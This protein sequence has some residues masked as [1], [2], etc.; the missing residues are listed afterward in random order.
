MPA[1]TRPP[2]RSAAAAREAV[3]VVPR[4]RVLPGGGWHGVR[5]T[6]L[7]QALE[8]IAACGEFRPRGEVEEEPSWQQVIPHMVVRTDHGL[9]V[10]RRLTASSEARLHHQL[11]LGV[12]GHI[13][14]ADAA[15]GGDPLTAGAV[16]EW[17]EEVLC[18]VALAATL[19]GLLKDD[20]APV[21]RVHLGLVL[22]V[23]A[24]AAPVAVRERRKLAGEVLA[25]AALRSRYLQLESWSQLVYDALVAGEL[26][27]PPE[28]AWRLQLP[29]AAAE[30]SASA[31]P[32][33]LPG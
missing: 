10:M 5:T 27:P 6:G 33:T 11:T 25:P 17:Q 30:T 12:G 8:T 16:R 26:E 4:A 2:L 3:L 23:E 13:N 9:L 1:G 7:R 21:G 28:P 14:R 18:P 15:R 31:H 19:V 22:L 24:G 20:T 29:P 32:S